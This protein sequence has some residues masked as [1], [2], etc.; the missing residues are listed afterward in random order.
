[1]IYMIRKIQNKVTQ[2][3]A[4]QWNGSN[5]VEVEEF[6]EQGSKHYEIG[7]NNDFIIHTL[8][9][10]MIANVNDWIIKGLNAEF[11]PC[12]PDIFEK[13]YEFVD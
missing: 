3:E 6:L 5:S 7:D 11:Y 12:K 2:K 9:G 10:N 13:S 8:E 1:M 4:I